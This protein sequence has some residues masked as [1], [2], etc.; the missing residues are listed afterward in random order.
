MR[1]RLEKSRE[2][3]KSNFKYGRGGFYDIDFIVSALAIEGRVPLPRSDTRERL[4]KLRDAGLLGGADCAVLIELSVF[5]RTLEH[6]VRIVS[7]RSRKTLPSSEPELLA[8]AGL[9]QSIPNGKKSPESLL[10][11]FETVCETVRTL[12]EQILKL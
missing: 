8:L 12:Y 2:S 7:G 1:A 11:V 3:D 9:V 6:S 10:E 5:F 4:V